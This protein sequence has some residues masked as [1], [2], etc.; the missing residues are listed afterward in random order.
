M[1]GF[2]PFMTV[3]PGGGYRPSSGHGKLANYYALLRAIHRLPHTPLDDTY[4]TRLQFSEHSSLANIA[5]L[6]EKKN[7]HAGEYTRN[8][9]PHANP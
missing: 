8:Y 2:T 5:K 4:D 7:Q 9:N 6:L 1:G 3:K